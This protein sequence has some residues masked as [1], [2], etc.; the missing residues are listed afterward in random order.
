MRASPR[1]SPPSGSGCAL[2]G[3]ASSRTAS[4]ARAPIPSQR[5]SARSTA[6]RVV[7]GGRLARAV[8]SRRSHGSTGTDVLRA[9]G[10]LEP[11]A[12]VEV[13]GHLRAPPS[14]DGFD[15]RTWLA[16]QGVHEVLRRARI[17]SSA[18]GAA[19]GCDRRDPP[20]RACRAH[21]P[22]ATARPSPT[23]WCWAGRA[24]DTRRWRVPRVGSRASARG[25]GP[26]R[27]PAG[28]GGG[29]PAPGSGSRAPL[30]AGDRG[31]P[32]TPRRRGRAIGRARGGTGVLVALAWLTG[33]RAPVARA[34]VVAAAGA[35]ARSLGGLGP[36]FQLSFAAVV[37]IHA[38]RP[39]RGWL[40]GTSCRP[41][42]QPLAISAACTLVT[43]PIA[44]TQFDR[45]RSSGACP[46]TCCAARRRAVPVPRASRPARCRRSRPAPWRYAAI[47]CSALRR[48]RRATGAWLDGA[49]GG[50]V[51][52]G[53]LAGLSVSRRGAG[54]P[55]ARCPAGSPASARVLCP[56]PARRALPRAR[57]GSRSSTSGKGMPHCSR[58]PAAALVEPARRR[59][60]RPASARAG[61]RRSMPWCSRTR[62]PTT[63]AGQRRCSLSSGRPLLDPG[64]ASDEQSSR[65]RSPRRAGATCV[66]RGR[67]GSCCGAARS[68]CGPGAAPRR[69]RRGPELGCARHRCG[70]GGMSRAAP[71]GRRGA[72][73][74]RPISPGECARGRPSW[75]GRS[76]AA[77][78]PA[79]PAPA[80]RR[81]LGG[82]RQ[83]LRAPRRPRRS[84][85]SRRRGSRSSAPTSTAT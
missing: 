5:R 42:V 41:P 3:A 26:E 47:A 53:L 74:V 38:S 58:R 64:L 30:S 67:A 50:G 21:A 18:G 27:R 55:A 51:L 81:H 6:A 1:R 56:R 35:R 52:L 31:R 43:A 45:S 84:R 83:L 80:A 20:E 17:D 15:Q 75:L 12:I 23:A 19:P 44:W 11:G 4:R 62:R 40:E 16:R 39:L 32:A 78:T 24:L 82:G 28:R 34:R 13:E 33:R 37:A 49:V 65:R 25:L 22:A 63:S 70:V 57:C 29:R 7:I 79:P 60:R 66:V 77:C 8:G 36:G 48:R 46:R 59:A 69:R 71:G 61:V 10:V 76:V 85:P 68:T 14:H 73:A 9:R 72:R 54:V 2:A